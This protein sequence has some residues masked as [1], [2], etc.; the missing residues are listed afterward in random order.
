MNT[1][2]TAHTSTITGMNTNSTGMGMSTSITD[3]S[4]TMSTVC[5]VR[6]R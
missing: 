3:M 4:T 5:A 6:L 2:N 1:A